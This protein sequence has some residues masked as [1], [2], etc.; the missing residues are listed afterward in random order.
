MNEP[1]AL[2]GAVRRVYDALR[3][4]GV[5][6]PIREFPAGTR[7]AADA[8]AAIG[9][10]VERIVKSLAF[11][12][13]DEVVIVLASGINRVDTARL[14]QLVGRPITRADA[15]RVRLA[16]GF[17]IGGVPPLGYPSPLRVFV[18]RD[19]L[20]YDEVWAAAGTPNAVFAIAPADLARVSE[21][22]IADVAED[23]GQRELSLPADAGSGARGQ[24]TERAHEP[25]NS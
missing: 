13:G 15:D 20:Q 19:L 4:R 12:A 1:E 3:A 24:R 17:A 7:T 9:T 22:R 6:P 11:A 25:P 21:A 18:D 2:K 10:G 5:E 8:A 23:G 14:G 16:T